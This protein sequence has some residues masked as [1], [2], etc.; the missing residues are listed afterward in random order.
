M[1]GAQAG[2]TQTSG[3][4]EFLGYDSHQWCERWLKR[5]RI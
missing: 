1:P 5:I 2:I 4:T 3:R